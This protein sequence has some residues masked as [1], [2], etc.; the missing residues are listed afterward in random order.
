ML[1]ILAEGL[2]N[3]IIITQARTSKILSILSLS[4]PVLKNYISLQFLNNQ[5]LLCSNVETDIFLRS[6]KVYKY[7]WTCFMT[8]KK[9]YAKR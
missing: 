1:D 6:H 3:K 7:S 9:N 4:A 8:S 5:Y 2:T